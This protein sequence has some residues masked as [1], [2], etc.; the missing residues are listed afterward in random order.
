MQLSKDLFQL[1]HTNLIYQYD[2][3][4][5]HKE[6]GN[7]GIEFKPNLDE[8]LKRYSAFWSKDLLD[9]PPIRVLALILWN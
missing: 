7:M 2:L 4:F 5:I 3:D 6:V 8:V 1:Y 9:H